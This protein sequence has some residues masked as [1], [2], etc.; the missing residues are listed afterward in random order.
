ME[1]SSQCDKEKESIA[2]VLSQLKEK[3]KANR[4]N[5]KLKDQLFPEKINLGQVSPFPQILQSFSNIPKTRTLSKSKTTI[6]S[7]FQ[8][9][10]SEK[11]PNELIP[12]QSNSCEIKEA[13][14]ILPFNGLQIQ[15]QI[16]IQKERKKIFS[17][18][19]KED[20]ADIK[21]SLNNTEKKNY[22]ERF[23]SESGKKISLSP[24]RVEK[25]F[26]F[27]ISP[28]N[29]PFHCSS[30]L[31]KSYFSSFSSI[32]DRKHDYNN[33]P[34][35][36]CSI[37]QTGTIQRIIPISKPSYPKPEVS[38]ACISKHIAS[39]FEETSDFL[40]KLLEVRDK[41][42]S[43]SRIFFYPQ[44]VFNFQ[45]LFIINYDSIITSAPVPIHVWKLFASISQQFQLILII[46]NTNPKKNDIP[47]EFEKRKIILAG[48]YYSNS[49][50]VHSR[51]LA[52]LLNYS[53]IYIDFHCKSPEKDCLIV[54]GHRLIEEPDDISDVVALNFG[55]KPKLNVE[56]AP[57][58]TFEYPN[59][60][61]A[62]LMGKS[63]VL[64]RGSFLGKIV[65]DIL[66]MIKK[67]Q[68]FLGKFEFSQIFRMEKYK[69][70]ETAIA[71][72]ILFE[73]MQRNLFKSIYQDSEAHQ[74]FQYCTVHSR[75]YLKYP[76]NYPKT[77]FVIK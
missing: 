71:D 74:R 64:S 48:L 33:S 76:S 40:P 69:I 63:E 13:S 58:A 27:S 72:F 75:H 44:S 68:N 55:I 73:T 30:I 8:P 70:V 11:N 57:V 38:C 52:K 62:V 51:E 23:V 35:P 28:K 41:I 54:T 53:Q 19:M 12:F 22:K 26:N 31:K 47:L 18:S 59:T 25:S 77:L 7:R 60:P 15:I 37:K 67:F 6:V 1:I 45:T 56:N 20:Q 17:R 46:S 4:L 34:Y 50:T 14:K 5:S 65:D 42:P 43:L 49:M 32:I 3:I 61:Y 21:I 2:S 16:P 39:S 9:K 24:L 66:A 10:K 36:Y 29:D